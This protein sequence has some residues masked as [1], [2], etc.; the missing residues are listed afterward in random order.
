MCDACDVGISAVRIQLLGPVRAW[1]G[2]VE[3]ELRGSTGRSVL[4]RL[5]LD[6]GAT[7]SVD[8]LTEA[9]WGEGPPARPV[10]NLQTAVSRLR[11][12]LGAD[13]I[14]TSTPGYALST[15]VEIDASELERALRE[16]DG[17]DP[18]DGAR[19]LGEQVARWEGPPLDDVADTW[20]FECYRVKLTELQLDALDRRDEYE[21]G[22]GHPDVVLPELW[23]RVE[24]APIRERT[25]L[26]LAEA[27][28]CVGRTTEAMRVLDEFRRSMVEL[29]GFDPS[30][31]FDALERRILA[32]SATDPD[33]QNPTHRPAVST[34]ER[35]S[36]PPDDLPCPAS[37]FVG[38]RRELRR[39]GELIRQH[40]IVTVT[41]VGGSGKTR[42]AI[43]AAAD[44]RS[45]APVR[46]VFVDL[47][48]VPPAGVADA[49]V[50]AAGWH[51]GGSAASV[52]DHAIARFIATR[53]LLVV[54]DN[55]EHV[56]DAVAELVH[57][58][59]AA[60]PDAR[61]LA[62][63]RAA[64]GVDG[65]R[66]FRIS[67]LGQNGLENEARELLFDRARSRND[68]FVLDDE[69]TVTELCRR[70][71]GLPLGIEL[72]AAQLGYLSVEDLMDRLDRR[73][74]LLSGGRSWDGRSPTLQSMMDWSW[75]LLDPAQRTLLAELSVF[76]G[77]F[78]V[79]AV[80]ALCANRSSRQPE[81][82]LRALVDASLVE[83]QRSERHLRYRLLETVRVFAARQL[84]DTGS[85]VSVK[86]RHRDWLVGWIEGASLGKHCY[87]SGWIADYS[88][89]L[90]DVHAAVD[91]SVEQNDWESAGRLLAAGSGAWRSGARCV[92]AVE[93]LQLVL[94]HELSPSL[95]V[96][97]LQAGSDAA[98]AAG[99]HGLMF[100]LG[101]AALDLVGSIDDADLTAIVAAW[102]GIFHMVSD[103]PRA[104][105]LVSAANSLAGDELVASWTSSAL[106]LTEHLAKLGEPMQL[107]TVAAWPADSVA[108]GGV[109]CVAAVNDAFGG[110]RDEALEWVGW[111]RNHGPNAAP[112]QHTADA[113]WV[114]VQALAGDPDEAM[115]SAPLV[116]ERLERTTEAVWRSELLLAIAVARFRLGDADR[117]LRYLER[118][119]TAPMNHPVF[120][121]LRR[122]LARK[123]RT[124][125]GDRG[126]IGEI[127]A[128]A[129][130]IDID[131]A[132]AD[133]LSS[134][135]VR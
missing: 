15:G 133:E 5:A 29:S 110:R 8:A 88:G 68:D 77:S 16:I 127:R 115:S 53:N 66:V 90:D 13:T 51:V 45:E 28:Y 117:A 95:R 78:D 11:K 71:D 128:T 57:R 70:L 40:R 25:R 116:L 113:V 134:G 72:A 31:R 14:E 50:H 64:L 101:S 132:L 37:R 12:V 52:R 83:A 106:L 125:V 47:L 74:E 48:S 62:T 131:R 120:Y 104:L 89:L 103:R 129:P 49:I 46:I 10:A 1:S 19:L 26:L 69:S 85:T 119:S 18:I 35:G 123:A 39:V 108:H 114:L 42:L 36:G 65:E 41:G 54:L 122:R 91:W 32:D 93:L 2:D 121:E 135:R 22:A 112:V 81:D 58:I 61:V 73:L 92:R 94:T 84:E 107:D 3:V 75:E 38:R 60:G 82:S 63:S 86:R 100:E 24:M 118:L 6:A 99:R 55:C 96:R 67:G 33:P 87:S 43:E 80:E 44:L 23:R 20:I 34:V 97:V 30:S 17:V 126:R 130:R 124:E 105:E 76:P 59:I 21:I 9:L 27:L 102:N 7:V 98:M 79:A 4:A 109:R 56:L 111:L